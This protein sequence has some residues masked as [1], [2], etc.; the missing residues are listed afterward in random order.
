[1]K[2]ATK[3]DEEV[4]VP[5]V[6]ERWAHGWIFYLGPHTKGFKLCLC[7]LGSGAKT[8]FMKCC[9]SKEEAK[10]DARAVAKA[11]EYAADL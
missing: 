1:M 4:E 8:I 5:G 7:I 10:A 3:Q 2:R 11:L 9:E 6:K